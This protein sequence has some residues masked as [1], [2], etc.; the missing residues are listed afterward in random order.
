MQDIEA[1]LQELYRT[2]KPFRIR[3]KIPS[4]WTYSFI[5]D[6]EKVVGFKI[7]CFED[8]MYEGKGVRIIFADG[9]KTL[10]TSSGSWKIFYYHFT[11]D[12]IIEPI[13]MKSNKGNKK[14]S[15]CNIPTELK[16]DFSNMEVREFCP[17]CKR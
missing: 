6:C 3:I 7:Q 4:M 11:K 17:R 8:D 2:Q 10:A 1:L 14:C 9:S 13:E 12:F 5:R 15:Y 16:R